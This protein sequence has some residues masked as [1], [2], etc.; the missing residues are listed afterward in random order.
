LIVRA[1][2]AIALAALL[3]AAGF[4][5][6]RLTADDEAQRAAPPPPPPLPIAPTVTS[7]V[8]KPPA[9]APLI[10]EGSRVERSW[11]FPRRGKYSNAHLLISWVRGG[12]D[13]EADFAERGLVVWSQ[14]GLPRPTGWWKNYALELH[15]QFLAP[16]VQR[17]DVT[18]DGWPEVLIIHANSGSGGCGPRRLLQLQHAEVS[19]LFARYM[20]DTSMELHSG[21]LHIGEG[22]Y[23]AGDA[24]CCPSFTRRTV[25]RWHGGRAKTIRSRLVR[26]TPSD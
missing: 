13:P 18:G 19:E 11:F 15:W 14:A 1:G 6:G 23:R 8:G 24:H 21:A 20:C 10:P 26:S 22:V 7:P 5:A 17:G 25:M 4:A 2:L 3:A 12:G 16:E 9:L